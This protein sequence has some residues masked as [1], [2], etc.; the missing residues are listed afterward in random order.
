MGI[1]TTSQPTTLTTVDSSAW[2]NAADDWLSNFNSKRTQRAYMQ[3]WRDFLAFVDRDATQVT[4]SD[5]IAYKGLLTDSGKSQS[6]INLRLSALSSFFS[7]AVERG[8][9]ANNPADGVKRKAVNPYG[10][11]TYLNAQKDEHHRFLA[12]IDLGTIQGKRDYAIMLLFLTTGVRVSAVT[13]A[14]MRDLEQRGSDWYLNY[15]NKGGE[16]DSAKL[17][18]P[19]M[20]AIRDYLATR[21]SLT[22]NSPLFTATER[23]KQAAR[24]SKRITTYTERPLSATTINNLVRKYARAAGLEGITAHSLRHTAAMKAMEHGTVNEVSKFLRHKNTRITTIYIDHIDTSS[25]DSLT[26]EL[27]AE[28]I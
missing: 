7:F 24:R 5:V 22:D 15:T 9:C 16:A 6:T 17:S 28:Y 25:A 1:I 10:K 2:A 26:D 11:A 19:V 4:Q 8:L 14:Y 27:S 18:Q 21:G 12:Q 20:A 3:A 13:S 23:G